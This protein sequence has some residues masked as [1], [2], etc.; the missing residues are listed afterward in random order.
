MFKVYSTAGGR[1]LANEYLPAAAIT[2]TVGTML[3]QKN[4]LLVAATGT[5][6]PTYMCMKTSESPVESG[7]VIP[8]IRV[9]PDT[10]FETEAEAD[11]SAVNLGQKIGLDDNGTGVVTTDGAAEVVYNDGTVVRVRFA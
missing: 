10:I 11:M 7:T 5:D 4:G 6:S 3:V 2:P 9:S 1:V 8:V